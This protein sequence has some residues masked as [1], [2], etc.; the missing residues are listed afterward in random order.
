M[1]PFL[2]AK[3][4]RTRTAVSWNQPQVNFFSV[5]L[6]KANAVGHIFADASKN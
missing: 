3:I 6:Y 5:F 1:K 2:L 4:F